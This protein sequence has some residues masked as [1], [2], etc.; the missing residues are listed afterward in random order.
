MNIKVFR[1]NNKTYKLL[2]KISIYERK[3]TAS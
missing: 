3:N 1:K 2:L